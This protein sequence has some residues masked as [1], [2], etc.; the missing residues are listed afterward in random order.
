[1][2]SLL[3][4]IRPYMVIVMLLFYRLHSFEAVLS[5]LLYHIRPF[6][7]TVMICF[8]DYSRSET[9]F[10][11]LSVL[12]MLVAHIFVFYS[13]KEP[14]YMFKRLSGIMHLIAGKDLYFD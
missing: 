3:Y 10:A 4:R 11:V 14:R 13:L 12:M 7:V 1:M 5:V 2:V 6:S 8:I 9:A